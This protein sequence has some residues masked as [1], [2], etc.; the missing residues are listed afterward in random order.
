VRGG[1]GKGL[2]FLAVVAA[3]LSLSGLFA[4]PLSAQYQPPAQSLTIHGKDAS[5]WTAGDANIVQLDGPV[6]ID[7]DRT[8]MTARQAVVWLREVRD[9]Q[10]GEQAVTVALIGDAQIRQPQATRSGQRLIVTARVNGPIRITA[11]DRT[12]RD[13]SGTATFKLA[14]AMREEVERRR[15]APPATAAPRP[16]RRGDAAATRAAATRPSSPVAVRAEDIQRVNSSDG[17]V[18]LALSGKVALSRTDEQGNHLEMQADRGV[19][20]TTLDRLR[21]L[22]DMQQIKSIEQA[23]AAAYLEGDV[24]VVVSSDDELKGEQRLEAQRVYYEFTTDRAVLTDAVMHTVDPQRQIPVIVRA[25]TVRQLSEGE[26]T[27]RDAELTTSSFA[28]PSYSVRADRIYVRQEETGDPRLGT[29]T[30]LSARH[31]TLNAFDVPFFYLPAVGGSITEQGFPLRSLSFGN[32]DNF[33]TSV[34]TRWGLLETLGQVPPRDLDASFTLDYFSERGPAGGID[35]TYGGGF[36]SQT[37][38]EAWNFEGEFK[39]YFVY[40]DGV[41]DLGRHRAPVE[42][43]DDFRGR[44]AWAHQ[45]FFPE[46]W[47]LQL[48]AA[49]LSDA[50]FLE[51]W[52]EDEY[53]NGLPLETSLYLKKQHD[54]EAITFLATIQPNSLVTTSDLVQEQFEVERIPELGYRRIGDSLAQDKLTFFSDNTVGI[55]KFKESDTSLVDQGFRFS[56]DV[57][58]GRPSLGLAGVSGAAGPPVVPEESNLRGDFRQEIDYPFSVGQFRV[59]PY[60][61]GRY[62]GYEEAVD[63]QAANRAFAGTGVRI[64]TQFWKIDNTAKSE[65]FDIHRV[66]HIVEPEIHLFASATN[67]DPDEL[68]I[69]E[70]PVDNIH[71]VQAAQFAIRQR[72]QTKRGG[73]GRLRS[74]DFLTLNVEANFFANQPNDAELAPLGFR[75]LFFDSLPEASIPRN[76]INADAEWRMSDST[77]LIS[78]AQYNLDEERLA[79][80]SIGLVARRDTRVTYFLGLRYIE[81]LDS[82]VGT[83]AATYELTRK[84]SV[85]FR[86]SYDFREEGGVYSSI[87]VQRKFDRF[88]MMFTAYNDSNDDVQG[89]GFALYPEGLAAGASSE[90]LGR[91][92]GGGG[93]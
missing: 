49:W 12:A 46:D 23:V 71:D 44:V 75:G 92:F 41:D 58:P 67:V 34:E 57:E 72:W 26:Y 69:Y 73:P 28:V 53:D 76:G 51:E 22:K 45:H 18:A 91:F 27:A 42:P 65:L 19:V 47:Q 32:S 86:Q 78:D 37:T 89:I 82:S 81:D 1:G 31:V 79:T 77:I 10:P 21:D 93:N 43:P 80:A 88:F 40:D 2:T 66:R 55:M 30:I 6:T 84:Y 9:G 15:P 85:G 61:M 70:E 64:H 13:L 29:R 39:S 16:G 87:N 17:K 59:V 14:V 33:G 63:G 25:Q 5:T 74:V 50:T 36:I 90:N 52:F 56:R 60:V 8:R 24:R 35:A 38:R 62:T 4:T 11:D 20:F 83:I 3:F 68:F 54:T 48:R 7:L